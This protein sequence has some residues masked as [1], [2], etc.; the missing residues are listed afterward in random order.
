MYSSTLEAPAVKPMRVLLVDDHPFLRQG[1]AL[2]LK[3]VPDLELTA[4]ADSFETALAAVN[5]EKPDVVV[6]DLSLPDKSGLELVRSLLAIHPDLPIL[7]LSMHEEDI[8]AERCLRAGAKG[9]LMK[10]HGPES[11]VEAI[12]M[13]GRGRVFVGPELAQKLVSILTTPAGVSGVR[14]DG[15]L[16]ELSDR[17]FE[18]FELIGRGKTAKEIA[19]ILN[20]SSKTVDVHR[21]RIRG[22]LDLSSSADLTHYA[23]RWVQSHEGAANL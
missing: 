20:L 2:T 6:T 15:G 19:G 14:R 13:V 9:F 22:K 10:S 8:Y 16:Q 23:V 17:E 21:A 12:R 11:L 3:N 5:H 4:E 18:V 1:V 7:V